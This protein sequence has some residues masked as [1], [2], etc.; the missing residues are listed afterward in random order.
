[1]KKQPDFY[2]NLAPFLQCKDYTVSEQLFDVKRNH[3]YDMLVTFPVPENLEEYY[4]SEKYISHTDN[5]SSINQK[6]QI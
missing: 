6:R 3:A 1:M 5:L 4:K 2:A